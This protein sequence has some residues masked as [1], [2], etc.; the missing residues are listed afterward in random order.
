MPAKK[1]TSAKKAAPAPAAPAP[2]PAAAAAPARECADLAAERPLRLSAP[3]LRLLRAAPR[4][5]TRA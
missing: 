1:V 3:P 2:A 4:A 5:R